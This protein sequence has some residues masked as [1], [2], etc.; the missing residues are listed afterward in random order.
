MKKLCMSF[1]CLFIPLASFGYES[2]ILNNVNVEVCF[3]PGSCGKQNIIKAIESA[4]SS[5]FV[6]AYGF[7]SQ[8]ISEALIKSYRKG[9][10]VNVILDKSQRKNSQGPY[11]NA[12]GIPVWYDSAHA[13]AHNK[14][15][16]IDNKTVITG[17][18][19]FTKAAEERNAE[20]LLIID[21]KELAKPYLENWLKHRAH[22]N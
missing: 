6:Q 10:A 1:L 4:N 18:Y 8:H 21:S 9:I 13:I 3:S 19:N 11:L 14:I 16:I 7:T 2:I 17:S 22:S 15:M 5:I 20:N 12:T